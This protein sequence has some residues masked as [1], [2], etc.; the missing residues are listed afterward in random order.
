MF[1]LFFCLIF[2]QRRTVWLKISDWIEIYK[3]SRE[4]TVVEVLT[5]NHMLV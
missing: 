3:E 4:G 2:C 1:A 5:S